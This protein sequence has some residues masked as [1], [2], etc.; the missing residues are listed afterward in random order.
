[1]FA[2]PIKREKRNLFCTLIILAAQKILFLKSLS[3]KKKS[4]KFVKNY[5]MIVVTCETYLKILF[6]CQPNIIL[7]FIWSIDHTSSQYLPEWC[8]S[9]SKGMGNLPDYLL[10]KS[11]FQPPI[12]QKS[13]KSFVDVPKNTPLF[14]MHLV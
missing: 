2:K 14:L 8:C 3:R 1:M 6:L 7:P 5:R 4:W 10:G 13:R 9:P 11:R 12:E